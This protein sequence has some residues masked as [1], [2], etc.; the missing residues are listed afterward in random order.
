MERPGHRSSAS[1]LELLVLADRLP[2]V[3]IAD[4]ARGALG[5]AHRVAEQASRAAFD[6]HVRRAAGGI[7][8]LA[9]A[10]RRAPP[11]PVGFIV[12]MVA[13][14]VLGLPGAPERTSSSVERRKHQQVC[15]ALLTRG[16]D[17]HIRCA[18]DTTSARNS[19]EF[20]RLL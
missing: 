10:T 18:I 20:D 8:G 1:C 2:K 9:D 15:I 5:I 13:G 19:H 4:Q 17:D 14:G 16:K 7:V 12:G 6:N 11:R 3:L